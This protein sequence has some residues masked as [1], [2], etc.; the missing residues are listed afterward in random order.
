MLKS[1]HFPDTVRVV[2]G[3]QKVLG[4]QFLMTVRLDIIDITCSIVLEKQREGIIFD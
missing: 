2:S 3:D 1:G 4:Y